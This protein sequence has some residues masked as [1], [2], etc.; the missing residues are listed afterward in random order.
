MLRISLRYS[1]QHAVA[2]AR[3]AREPFTAVLINPIITQLAYFT[4]SIMHRKCR[5]MSP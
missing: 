3:G 4:V 1:R 2:L 5:R